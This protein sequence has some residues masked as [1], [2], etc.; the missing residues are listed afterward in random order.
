MSVEIMLRT[1]Y[2]LIER[3]LFSTGG[4]GSWGTGAASSPPHT[5]HPT[6]RHKGMECTISDHL[7]RFLSLNVIMSNVQQR[8]KSISSVKDF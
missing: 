8:W 7:C 1:L 6:T 2:F 5:S 4:P 3:F